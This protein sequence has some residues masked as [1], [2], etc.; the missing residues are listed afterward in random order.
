L[1]LGARTVNAQVTEI[2]YKLDPDTQQHLAAKRLARNDIAVCNI[3][4]DHAVPYAPLA[5]A[6]ALGAFVLTDR[7]TGA[8]VA[9]GVIDFALRRAENVH[10]QQLAVDR[11]ARARIKQ[12]TPG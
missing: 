10:W 1:Q 6:P 3:S 9:A 12:Q 7:E 5:R 4:L 2:K 11:A 8:P